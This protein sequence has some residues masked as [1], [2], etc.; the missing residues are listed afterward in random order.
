MWIATNQLSK[1]HAG[2]AIIAQIILVD[3]ADGQQ[4]LDTMLAARIF[5]A[6]V[7]VMAN[8]SVQNHVIFEVTTHLGGEFSD[9]E[10]AAF[11]FAGS[12]RFKNDA[13]VGCDYCLILTV[14]ARLLGASF[15]RLTLGFSLVELSLRPGLG[16]MN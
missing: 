2:I 16:T 4:R 3:L 14:R 9:S 7:L 15:E 13:A 11:G 6:Q 5:A 8:R 10:C 1:C 12:G